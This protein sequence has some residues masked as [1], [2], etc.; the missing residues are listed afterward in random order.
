MT[1]P[2]IEIVQALGASQEM[3][4]FEAFTSPSRQS[5]GSIVTEPTAPEANNRS[6]IDISL[7]TLKF[8]RSKKLISDLKD[9]T[10]LEIAEDHNINI[11]YECRASVCG[12]CK[13]KLLE[14]E[15]FMES[16]DSLTLSDRA[17]GVILSCQSH[18]IG[19][20]VVDL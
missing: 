12:K 3:I 11:P 19:N 17:N 10:I 6:L 4:L 9:K 15:V 16:E 2:V 7:S 20:V 5:S 1:D 18:C 13:I 8:A 14:G